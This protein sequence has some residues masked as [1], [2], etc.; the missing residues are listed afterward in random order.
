MT[1][2]IL[3]VPYAFRM[4]TDKDDMALCDNNGYCDAYAKVIAI[5]REF[6][7]NH[8]NSIKD[9]IAHQQTV[10]RHEVIHAY[11]FE[12]GLTGYAENEELVSWIAWQFPKLIETFQ[13]IG[14][15]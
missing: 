12:S 10:K 14:A 4:T 8:P 5:E 1:I 2:R 3:G 9:P 13:E 6:H 7:D 15:I 11:L